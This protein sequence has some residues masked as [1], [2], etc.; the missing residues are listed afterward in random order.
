MILS[1]GFGKNGIHHDKRNKLIKCLPH[2]ESFNFCTSNSFLCTLVWFDF[3]IQLFLMIHALDILWRFHSFSDPDGPWLP[4][5]F[6]HGRLYTWISF[7]NGIFNRFISDSVFIFLLMKDRQGATAS[8]F[9]DDLFSWKWHIVTFWKS[10]HKYKDIWCDQ[11]MSKKCSRTF[12]WK[13]PWSQSH[14]RK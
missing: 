8:S 14:V 6:L 5:I 7:S 3:S 12:S 1:H 9:L 2:F 11:D 13:Y 4:P 10:E